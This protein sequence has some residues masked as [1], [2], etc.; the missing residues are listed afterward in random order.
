MK[1]STLLHALLD[2]S[3]NR[4]MARETFSVNLIPAA[5]S[6]EAQFKMT[7]L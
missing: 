3:F 7:P 1:L 4:V 2:Q 5:L 6:R